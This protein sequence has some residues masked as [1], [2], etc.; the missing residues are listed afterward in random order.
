V[1]SLGNDGDRSIE[2]G[3]IEGLH[4]QGHRDQPR[5]KLFDRLTRQGLF[6]S[7]SSANFALSCCPLSDD[8]NHPF[9]KPCTFVHATLMRIRNVLDIVRV[10]RMGPLSQLETAPQNTADFFD[11]RAL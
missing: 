4:E 5:K 8:C 11:P 6:F 1:Q 9:A 3:G 2:D 7:E 10:R